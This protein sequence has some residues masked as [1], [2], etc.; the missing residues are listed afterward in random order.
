M[1]AGVPIVATALPSLQDILRHGDNAWLVKS[2]DAHV[3]AEGLRSVL[4]DATLRSRLARQA[5]QDAK[6]FSWNARASAI[7]HHLKL[8]P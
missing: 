6:R 8:I 1:A 4:H 5:Q 2:I 3:L 7:L